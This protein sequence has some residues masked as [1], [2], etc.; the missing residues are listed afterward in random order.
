[1]GVPGECYPGAQFVPGCAPDDAGCTASVCSV[2]GCLGPAP[3]GCFTACDPIALPQ[4]QLCATTACECDR[5]TGSWAC[6]SIC[7]D[8]IPLSLT[9]FL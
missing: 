9:C 8:Q 5:N 6:Q 7:I 3:L 4:C 1:M 2:P